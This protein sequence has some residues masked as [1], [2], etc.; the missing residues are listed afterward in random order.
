MNP[1]FRLA[2]AVAA[3]ALATPA[4]ALTTSTVGPTTTYTENFN[5]GVGN[6]NAFTGG[7]VLPSLIPGDSYLALSVLAGNPASATFSIATAIE[8]LSFQF[9]YLGLFIGSSVD[10]SFSVTGPGGLLT[11]GNLSNN[12]VLLNPGPSGASFA[13]AVFNNLAAGD[14][15]FTFTRNTANLLNALHVDDFQLTVTAVP[16]PATV[17]LVLAGLGVLGVAARRRRAGAAAHP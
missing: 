11:S 7:T 5:G 9:N 6:A 2:S 4:M 14:Y 10:G 8:S 3:L 13:S 15:T 16:E 17:G 1:T 12:S